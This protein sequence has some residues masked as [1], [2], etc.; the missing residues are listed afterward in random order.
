MLAFGEWGGDG[1]QVVTSSTTT[2]VLL[3]CTFGDFPGSIALDAN[4]RFAVNGSWNPSVGPIQQNATMPAQMS[5][6]VVGTTLT[7]AVA[8]NDTTRK[9][10]TSLGP[11]SVVFGKQAALTVCP[12]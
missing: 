12:V 7:F 2:H 8:V 11:R 9:Q 4:G 10:V 5:G 6:Q 3:G 1:A